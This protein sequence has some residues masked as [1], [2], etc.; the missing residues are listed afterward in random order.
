MPLR[1]YISPRPDQ[2]DY[3][4]D[5]VIELPAD[6]AHYV[7]RVMRLRS[8]ASLEAFD[9]HG[10]CL[11]CEVQITGPRACHL[12]V[13]AVHQL[14]AAGVGA[15]MY[16]ALLKGAAMDRALAQCVEAGARVI[17]LFAAD[18]S[19]ARLEAGRT[20]NKLAHWQKVLIGACEQCGQTHLPE[21]AVAASLPQLDI[22][23]LPG[24]QLFLHQ[25]GSR[26][27]TSPAAPVHVFVGPEGGWSEAEI[28]LLSK[29]AQ[30][31]GL[32]ELTLRA[33]SIPAAFLTLLDHLGI[34][35]G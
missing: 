23:Q 2:T 33:E 25:G 11:T 10:N 29:H 19:N 7:R 27:D 9:G 32:G 17:T 14:P 8:G 35:T 3:T 26:L 18:R 30:M 24:T 28:N 31:V 16:L 6:R 21:L 20:E 13:Q 34:A 12:R 5:S 1:F 4:P 15:H 22:E